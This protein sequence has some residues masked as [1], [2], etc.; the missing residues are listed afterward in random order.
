MNSIQKLR[1]E[2]NKI[3][4]RLNKEN[5]KIFTDIVV[6]IASSSIS[7]REQ[8][9]IFL[10]ILDMFLRAQNDGKPVSETIGSDYK[11]FCDSV[12]E[13]YP[14]HKVNKSMILSYAEILFQGILILLTID[15]AF[16]YLPQIIKDRTFGN[17]NLMFSSILTYLAIMVF[18]IGIVKYIMK[19]SFKLS[20]IKT[21]KIRD[22]IIGASFYAL[23]LL[24]AFVY[25]K[26]FLKYD[27]VIL[28]VKIYY[29]LLIIGAYWIY[30]I[31][32]GITHKIYVRNL[33]RK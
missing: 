27:V 23:I 17:Y 25:Y 20:K 9:D 3:A 28:S 19:N 21:S 10:D 14:T 7:E 22:F 12:I 29:I 4:E 32:S 13:A 26:V 6:Y 33:T 30:R 2:R 16:N 15:V 5:S 11:A 18:S 31:I 24:A 8:E 1:D